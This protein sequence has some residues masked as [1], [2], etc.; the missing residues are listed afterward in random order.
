MSTL[1]IGID[2]GAWDVFDPLC[3]L[4]E[5]PNLANLRTRGVWGTLNAL[6]PVTPAPA[7]ATM[8]T[9]VNPGRHGILSEYR[10]GASSTIPLGADGPLISRKDIRLPLLWERLSDHGMTVGTVNMP[11]SYPVR[12]INGFAISGMFTPPQ[13]QNW[14]HPT[15]LAASLSDYIIE[16]DYCKP[17]HRLEQRDLPSPLT[18][19]D[20]IMLMTERRGMHSLR[21]MRDQEWDVFSVV[22]TGVSHIFQYFWRYLRPE[23][24]SATRYLDIRV[25]E[26]LQK[27]FTLLDQILGALI[28]MAGEKSHILLYSTFGYKSAARNLVH[29]NNWLLDLDILRLRNDQKRKRPHS[30]EHS[31][32]SQKLNDPAKRVLPAHAR[33]A[34]QRYGNL[35]NAI[36]WDNTLA[37]SMPLDANTAGIF[38]HGSNRKPAGPVSPA[39]ASGLR[40]FLMAQA[41]ALR[42]PGQGAPLIT[43]IQTREE[44][45]QGPHVEFFPDIILT[46]APDHTSVADLGSTLITPIHPTQ[47]LSSGD[48]TDQGMF[49]AAGPQILGHELA[50]AISLLDLAP[51]ILHITNVPIPKIM[52]GQVIDLS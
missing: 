37:W 21:L 18:L 14:T 26:K 34:I 3:N 29:L 36:D 33:K 17:G 52:E 31:V 43:K 42:I 30:L 45:Y 24:A 16:L 32:F 1:L 10:I 7:W 13:A 48:R 11:L 28:K 23:A 49:L 38:F 15:A 40:D 9:G 5:M 4:G 35:T 8:L 19:M 6:K 39:D 20:D 2:G 50:K 12:P 44:L 46:L 27:Y 41:S 47:R 22:F 25:A 51:T